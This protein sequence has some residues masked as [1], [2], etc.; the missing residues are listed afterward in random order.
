MDAGVDSHDVVFLVVDGHVAADGVH[1][2]DGVLG[3]Q[4]VG[5]RGVGEGAVVECSHWADISQVAAQFRVQHLLDVGVD[6]GGPASS[7]G[8]QVV[9]A[10]DFLCEPDAAGAV[11]APVH[12]G[13]DER[14]Y[15]LVL[16]CPL[17]LVVPAGL[18]AVEVGVVLQV[19]LSSLIADGAVEGVV[20]QQELH[21]SSACEAG[22]FGV[23]LDLHGGGDLRAAGGDGLGGLLYL[24]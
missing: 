10:S 7:R 11:D 2:V 3:E 19:A 22:Y 14:S 12:V 6:L 9:E 4:L 23:G 18:V 17:V 13:D 24:H 21:D 5:P 20:S 16:H 1:E 15:V 8:A